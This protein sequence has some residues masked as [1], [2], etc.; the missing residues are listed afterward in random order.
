MR[1]YSPPMDAPT[2]TYGGG[3]PARLNNSWRSLTTD[4]LVLGPRG[5]SLHPTPARSYQQARVKFAMLVCMDVH[6]Y[7]GPLPPVSKMTADCPGPN[8]RGLK[9]ARP[10]RRP[11]QSVE[12]DDFCHGFSQSARR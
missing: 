6:S 5:G 11:A 9:C 12:A 2:S 3:T 1:A 8:S 7:P 4:V 10:H